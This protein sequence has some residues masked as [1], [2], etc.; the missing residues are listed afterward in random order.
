[1]T[2]TR[3]KFE[4]SNFSNNIVSQVLVTKYFVDRNDYPD[5][6]GRSRDEGEI[7]IFTYVD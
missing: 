3:D 7:S 5:D 2:G 4:P 6:N 1:M